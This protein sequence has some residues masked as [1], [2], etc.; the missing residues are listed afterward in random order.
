MIGKSFTRYAANV[1]AAVG[2]A[3]LL[4]GLTAVSAA[5]AAEIKVMST[6]AMSATLDELKLK[7]ETATG[8][9]VVIWTCRGD[10]NQEWTLEPDGTIRH[11]GNFCLDTSGGKAVLNPCSSSA[12]QI[13]TPLNTKNYELVQ[14]ASGLCLTLPGDNTV[15]G[16]QPDLEKCQGLSYQTWRMPAI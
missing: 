1:G 4:L 11:Q 3:F 9:K 12:T 8:N 13:W 16:T 5:R 14:K 6:V 15:D 2:L 7:F 10:V